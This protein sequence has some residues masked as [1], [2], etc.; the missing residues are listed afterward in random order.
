M[1]ERSFEFKFRMYA[2][3]LE[4]SSEDQKIYNAAI[5]ARE[6]AYAP[7]SLFKVGAALLLENGEVFQGNNQENM[8]Y[9]SGLCAE[10]VAV[11]AASANR[12]GINFKTLAIVAGT[13]SDN[14][15]VDISP[16][17]S[18]R[19]VIAEYERLFENPIRIL[20]GSETGPIREI[21]SITS[22]LPFMFYEPAL[23]KENKPV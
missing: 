19:Q 6:N 13:D 11:F 16:C 18:C 20:M 17:G 2:S 9:P 1:K 7:Y 4:L 23:K 14:K 3:K 22:L 15:E 10:R 12:P 21:S 8:A 5:E